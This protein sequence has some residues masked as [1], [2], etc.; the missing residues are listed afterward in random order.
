[1]IVLLIGFVLSGCGE[2]KVVIP[3]RNLETA[4]REAIE[5]PVGH[6]TAED[7]KKLEVIQAVDKGITNLSGLEYAENLLGLD[8]PLNSVSDLS[9]LSK[10]QNLEWIDVAHNKIKDLSPL[11]DLP[12]IYRIYAGANQI[13][14]IKTLAKF[15]NV[16]NLNL[17]EN[18]IKDI[19]SLLEMPRLE[20]VDVEYNNLNLQDA[21]TVQV[22][23]TL[24]KAGVK[25]SYEEQRI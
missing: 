6:L 17:T 18:N 14:D 1:M 20:R 13:E 5:K 23:N 24:L 11:A 19:S 15:K 4:V 3:D 10:L 25:V 8:I 22:I 7:M 16:F 9:P 21:Q 2:K 12:K